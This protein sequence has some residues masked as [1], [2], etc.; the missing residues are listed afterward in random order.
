MKCPERPTPRVWLQITDVLKHDIYHNK[1]ANLHPGQPLHLQISNAFRL[2]IEIVTLTCLK[3]DFFV[4]MNS[5]RLSNLFIICMAMHHSKICIHTWGT[6]SFCF[7]PLPNK[8]SITDIQRNYDKQE[9]LSLFALI[10]HCLNFNQAVHQFSVR[11]MNPLGLFS[12]YF[13][14]FL[15]LFNST[16]SL[17]KWICLSCLHFTSIPKVLM[18]QIQTKHCPQVPIFFSKRFTYPLPF[19]TSACQGDIWFRDVLAII[20]RSFQS[21]DSLFR[22]ITTSGKLQKFPRFY[23]SA[24]FLLFQLPHQ[25]QLSD[26]ASTS[27]SPL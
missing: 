2:A 11:A 3:Q 17:S 13:N 8:R 24:F 26:I 7:H 4:S 21:G 1:Q 16:T 14:S 9:I 27:C 5:C 10:A 20:S 15:H 12:D 23:Y 18:S 19:L 22:T 6:L 25:S